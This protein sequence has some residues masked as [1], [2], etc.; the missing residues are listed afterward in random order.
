MWVTGRLWWDFASF[1]PDFPPET[2]LIIRRIVRDN[3]YIDRLQ[4]EIKRFM[5]EVVAD[6]EFASN[7]R[8][9]A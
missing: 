5:A 7:Y 9:P 2:R 4:S 6:V 3:A 8:E 1:H